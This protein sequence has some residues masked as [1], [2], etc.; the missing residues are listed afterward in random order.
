VRVHVG[1]Q[2]RT[3]SGGGSSVSHLGSMKACRT[4]TGHCSQSGL[5]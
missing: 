4:D 1:G 2:R 5:P 3:G